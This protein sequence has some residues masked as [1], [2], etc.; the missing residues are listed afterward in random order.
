MLIFR[1]QKSLHLAIGAKLGL[2]VVAAMLL[3]GCE[4][5]VHQKPGSG[6]QLS[7][8]EAQTN[9]P[10]YLYLPA[11]YNSNKRWPLVLAIH[12]IKPF[13]GAD[14]QIR[15][16][17]STADKHGLIVVAPVVSNTNMLLM[18]PLNQITAG[19]KREEQA[20]MNILD[21]VLSHTAADPDRVLITG[22]SSGGHLMH[23]FANQY[24]ERFAALCS[25][26]CNF[27]S[28]A[29]SEDNARRMA[30]R[31]F[32][33]MIYTAEYDFPDVNFDS[34]MAIRWYRKM[35]FNV[36]TAVIPQTIRL[37]ALGLGHTEGSRPDIAAEFFLRSTQAA[38]A[39]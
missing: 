26:C 2:L 19:V 24:P 35:G 17:Q 12:A 21:E 23:Y 28:A 36:E 22:L 5:A 29:L 13:D 27:T 6:T 38:P 3:S 11:G 33:V 10:Y 32:P 34:W 16:W 20:V 31:N 25:R 30:R 8:K 1:A 14:R 39:D 9:A 18:I 15:E 4:L 37:P 7:L